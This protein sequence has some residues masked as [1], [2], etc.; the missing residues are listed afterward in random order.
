M[1]ATVWANVLE[2]GQIT[3]SV[4][5]NGSIMDQ[6]RPESDQK[7]DQMHQ[8]LDLIK[9]NPKISRAELSEKTGLHDSSVKRRLKALVDEGFIQR[10]GP[11]KG[12]Y[13]QLLK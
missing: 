4:G 11:D 9:R 13:W 8:I 7:S 12:G 2:D 6:K 3:N 5:A 1:K 10:I